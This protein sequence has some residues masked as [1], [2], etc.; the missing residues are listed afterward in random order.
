MKYLFLLMLTCFGLQAYNQTVRLKG[1]I[2]SDE[3]VIAGARILIQP[4][5]IGTE[6]DTSGHF[7]VRFQATSFTLTATAVGY[8]PYK[9]TFNHLTGDTLIVLDMVLQSYQTE[10]V[11]ITG[12]LKEVSKMD[13]PIPVESYKVEYFAKTNNSNLF[14]SLSM[15]NGVKPTLNCNV[16]NTGDIHI[17]GMEGP[18]TMITLDGMP[19]VSGLSTV[20]G[21]SGI[22]NS[23]I[24]RVEVVKGPAGA[25]Y[26]SEAVGGLINIITKNPANAPKV[27]FNSWLSSY[28]ESNTDL[29]TAIRV[30]QKVSTLLS[31]NHYY[32]NTR[33]DKNNDN[34]TDLTLQKRTAF[35]NKW[36]FHRKD[37]REANIAVRYFYEDRF[38][39]EMNWNR[40]HRGGDQVYGESIFTHRVEFLGGYQ[41]PIKGEKIKW[42]TSF[43]YHDQN[44]VYG[45]VSYLGQQ[46]VAFNQLL[47]DK[48]VRRHDLLAGIAHRYTYY[49][50][51]TPVTYDSLKGNQPS[52][53][54]LP[55]I[56]IQDQYSFTE[57][58]RVLAGL[59]Y[60]YSTVHRHIFSPRLAIQYKASD[61]TTVRLMGG[62]GFRVVNVFT[63]DHAALTGSRKVI[64]KENLQPERSW[65]AN[66]NFYHTILLPKGY[67]IVDASA[68]YSRFQNKIIADYLTDPNTVFY[69]NLKGYAVSRGFTLNTE[70][71]FAFPLKVQLGATIMEVFQSNPDSAGIWHRTEQVFTPAMIGTYVITYKFHRQGLNIDVNG[72]VYSPMRLPVQKHD[73]RPERSPWFVFLNVQLTKQ[74]KKGWEIY[75]GGKNLLDFFPGNP[76]M[77][78]FDPFDK[79]VNENN[80]NGYTFDTSYNFA[81]LQRRHFF[82]GLRWTL[83]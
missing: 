1:T 57:K 14:E 39:G 79:K 71:N 8:L 11:V 20:Y 51:N 25:L 77:R 5:N 16:C 22:P 40:N 64:F 7:E 21:L 47:W 28:L 53:I 60:D 65:N 32:F 45:R 34:F 24:E 55:G 70:F 29:S 81:P 69:Q 6:S 63:E 59:R 10:D 17:N 36:K 72:Q 83:N 23:I 78:P 30:S 66:L 76:L 35:F 27:Y 42:Q 43:N 26:G 9:Q 33:W 44:S 38:G 4:A 37:E 73:F 46:A 50:D 80:P 18:Y 12:T 13:S 41:L 15:V 67:F 3:E 54:S 49:D 58:W 56:F 61:R 62:N 48:R 52:R 31:L 75:A 19:I 2:R 74:L 68:F 82:I